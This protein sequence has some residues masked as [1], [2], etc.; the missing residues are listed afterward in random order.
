MF[1]SG[2]FSIPGLLLAAIF[3][4][5]YFIPLSLMGWTMLL[6]L[7]LFVHFLGQGLAAY[8]LAH[9]PASFTSIA[10]LGEPVV[11]TIL[12]WII[13]S[14]HVGFI[15]ST[16]CIIVLIGIWWSQRISVK[17]SPTE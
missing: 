16:G 2:L 7:A 3:T 1:W 6:C 13:L 14:E 17:S 5:E 8:A 10:F 4:G 9:L 12:G 15:Q 11:A